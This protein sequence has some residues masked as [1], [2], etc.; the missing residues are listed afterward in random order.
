MFDQ[1]PPQRSRL[2]TLALP[3]SQRIAQTS[4]TPTDG[5]EPKPKHHFKNKS[6]ISNSISGSQASDQNSA[7]NFNSAQSKEESKA[8]LAPKKSESPR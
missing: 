3:K 7:A 4:L 8:K 2:D 6:T 5:G 1:P